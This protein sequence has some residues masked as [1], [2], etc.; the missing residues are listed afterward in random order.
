LP[1]GSRPVTANSR[2]RDVSNQQDD[3]T[4]PRS[5]VVIWS[6]CRKINA[7]P[8]SRIPN[9]KSK[10]LRTPLSATTVA[11]YG[12]AS[13]PEPDGGETRDTQPLQPL[14]AACRQLS[15]G[16]AGGIAVGANSVSDLVG[17]AGPFPDIAACIHSRNLVDGQR[18]GYAPQHSLLR[19]RP[20]IVII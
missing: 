17:V 10:G 5:D 19:H 12:M 18:I 2:G 15:A 3:Q 4:G 7:A 20:Q 16:Q 8:D 11:S 9:A 6:L 1:A 13:K 14:S